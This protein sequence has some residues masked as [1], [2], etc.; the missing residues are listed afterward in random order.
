MWQMN[1]PIDQR[2][3]DLPP[4]SEPPVA[5]LLLGHASVYSAIHRF[6]ALCLLDANCGLDNIKGPAAHFLRNA[7]DIF[8]HHTQGNH[9]ETAH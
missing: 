5:L 6:S 9:V 2:G 1:F 7:A 3:N 8:T 4:T